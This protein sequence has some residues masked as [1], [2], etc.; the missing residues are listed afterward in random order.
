[1]SKQTASS[2]SNDRGSNYRPAFW[3]LKAAREGDTRDMK[4]RYK[5]LVAL[6]KR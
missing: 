2:T 3:A 1:V 4:R 6:K 5:T